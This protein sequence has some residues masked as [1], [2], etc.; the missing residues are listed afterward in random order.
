MAEAKSLQFGLLLCLQ[1][2][3]NMLDQ[4]L[5]S[6][7]SSGE[8]GKWSICHTIANTRS[9]LRQCQGQPIHIFREANTFC[10]CISF[11]M[12]LV[13]FRDLTNLVID[14]CGASR[15]SYERP[16]TLGYFIRHW[17]LIGLEFLWFGALPNRVLGLLHL[18]SYVF[19][20]F[21]YYM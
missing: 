12:S 3:F 7:V 16:V 15:E 4:V 8:H 9:L 13:A 18:V 19:L 10:K 17:T 14:L 11:L 6:L 5:V 2:G 21:V 1:C 20:F